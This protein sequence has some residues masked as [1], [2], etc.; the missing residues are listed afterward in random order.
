MTEVELPISEPVVPKLSI[1]SARAPNPFTI[2][3][4]E[5]EFESAA[6]ESERI[7]TER[8]N[9]LKLSVVERNK[10][11]QPK[12]PLRQYS[13]RI[14]HSSSPVSA[15]QFNKDTYH[16]KQRIDEKIAEKR[17]IYLIQLILNQKGKNLD[18]LVQQME[19]EKE[20]VEV[21]ENKIIEESHQCQR[22]SDRIELELQKGRKRAEQATQARVD[23]E[24]VLHKRDNINGVIQSE[25]SRNE[26][27]LIQYQQYYEF[28][29]QVKPDNMELEDMFKAPDI[30]I[31]IIENEER[32]NLFLNQQLDILEDMASRGND[33]AEHQLVDLKTT[34]SNLESTIN[35]NI[36]PV[37]KSYEEDPANQEPSEE[38]TTTREPTELELLSSRV[39]KLFVDCF[40]KRASLT[41]IECLERL[42]AKLEEF[43]RECDRVNPDF[44]REKQNIIDN[45]RKEEA[46]KQIIIERERMLLEKKEHAL[47]RATRPIK[48]RTGRKLM[49]RYFPNVVKKKSDEQILLQQKEKERIQNLLYGEEN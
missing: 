9:Y 39:L 16:R 10:L 24:K 8:R 1:R 43:Y 13:P 26:D 23:I 40:K 35:K 29:Q 11:L 15:R 2:R 34:I 31:K 14:Q 18:Q 32:D 22:E 42:E 4:E 27:Y 25:I 41:P 30:L 38:E 28:L 17:D 46:R 7:K 47:A 5:L 37:L 48:K 45:A 20:M 36:I 44:I 19:N 3:P 6:I 21:T 12:V 49:E 33:T